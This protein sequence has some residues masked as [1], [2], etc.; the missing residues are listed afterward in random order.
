MSTGQAAIARA[1]QTIMA[2]LGGNLV[3]Q[4]AQIT[5]TTTYVTVTATDS[6]ILANNPSRKYLAIV[7]RDVGDADLAFDTVAVA[8]H[9]IPVS[10]A[11]SLGAQ[12]GGYIFESVV[13][14][15]AV[16]AVTATGVITH[17]VVVEGV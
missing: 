4:N 13:P 5:L 3:V 15:G 8:G 1:L 17:L 14:G 7:N 16:H 10:S 6:I 2:S 9:G 11:A 12:G